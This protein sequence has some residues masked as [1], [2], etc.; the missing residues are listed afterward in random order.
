MT[1]TSPKYAVRCADYTTRPVN[2]RE[3][4]ERQLRGIEAAGQCANEHEVIEVDA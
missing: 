1:T 2:T 4:A 3:Q